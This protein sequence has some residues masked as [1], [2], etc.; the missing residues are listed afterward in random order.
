MLT[1]PPIYEPLT[2]DSFGRINSSAWIIWLQQLT[3]ESAITDL[4][5]TNV[6]LQTSDSTTVLN[7]FEDALI[8]AYSNTETATSL[9]NEDSMM[10]SWLSF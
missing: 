2:L 10:F 8:L 7:S 1:P 3:S 6:F 4:V 5:N 9:N